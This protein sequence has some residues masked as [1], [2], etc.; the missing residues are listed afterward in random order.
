VA[1]TVPFDLAQITSGANRSNPRSGDP[2]GTLSSTGRSAVAFGH[3]NSI[4]PTASVDV[5]NA[6][7]DG[8]GQGGGSVAADSAVR[9]LTP[10]ECERLQGFPDGWT[11]TSYGRAQSDSARYR[12]LGNSIAVPVFVWVARRIVDVNGT[13]SD[14]VNQ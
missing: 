2:N 5:T 1:L 7:R 11:A 12:Q 6:V 14:T 13:L 9:R 8:G 3:K 10:V 4:G